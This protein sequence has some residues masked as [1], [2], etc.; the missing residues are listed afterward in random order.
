MLQWHRIRMLQSHRRPVIQYNVVQTWGLLTAKTAE[1]QLKLE[2][3]KALEQ[4]YVMATLRMSRRSGQSELK[5]CIHLTD[6]IDLDGDK[7]LYQLTLDC[8]KV[9]QVAYLVVSV[10]TKELS[11]S[12]L[13]AVSI[14]PKGIL[15]LSQWHCIRILHYSLSPATCHPVQCRPNMR[16]ADCATVWVCK[17][18]KLIYLS[19]LHLT[20]FDINIKEYKSTVYIK[21]CF[22]LFQSNEPVLALW[23]S[24]RG[25]NFCGCSD[26][27]QNIINGG[28]WVLLRTNRL[29]LFK[30]W[31]PKATTAE[32]QLK[33]EMVKP[34]LS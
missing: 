29:A 17:C 21:H 7:L 12:V 13:L 28:V 31:E 1:K 27:P 11:E 15:L 23:P 16:V 6:R 30:S 4:P 10:A 33:L 9:R 18:L 25:L 14:A 24:T 5:R 8:G 20:L 2:L 34:N 22:R 26:L 32:K 3:G 19:A